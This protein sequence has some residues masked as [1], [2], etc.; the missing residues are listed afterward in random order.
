V[1]EIEDNGRG[2]PEKDLP[3][4]FEKFYRGGNSGGGAQPGAE[5]VPGIGLGLNLA[6]VLIE[7]MNGEVAVESRLAQGTK[8]SV[9]LPVWNGNNQAEDVKLVESPAAGQREKVYGAVDSVADKGVCYEQT[10]THR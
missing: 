3:R 1:I 9:R 10:I 8:F 7:G 2:I 5:E 4:I 6:K